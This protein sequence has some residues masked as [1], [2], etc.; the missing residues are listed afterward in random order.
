MKIKVGINFE[1]ISIG[2]FSC[3]GREA[4]YIYFSSSQTSK[5][6]SIPKS[7]DPE[8]T[9]P[10]FREWR[11]CSGFIQP[12]WQRLQPER[13]RLGTYETSIVCAAQWKCNRFIS[14]Y[15]AERTGPHCLAVGYPQ[16]CSQSNW[17]LWPSVIDPDKTS[18]GR[19]LA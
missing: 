15:A 13:P 7:L 8:G 19:S 1:L 5:I 14:P 2:L 11:L 4:L 6:P 16:C 12:K 18:P 17:N 3:S 10:P 9:L